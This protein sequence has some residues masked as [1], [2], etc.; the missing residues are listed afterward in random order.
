M[1]SLESLSSLS[2]PVELNSPQLVPTEQ[3]T[4][5]V[6]TNDESS[7]SALPSTP[8]PQPQNTHSMQTR[9]KSSIVQ[10]R[11]IQLYF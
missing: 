4:S 10:P 2:Q 5:S 3:A 8:P 6:L 11:Y 9:S 1:E 7:P